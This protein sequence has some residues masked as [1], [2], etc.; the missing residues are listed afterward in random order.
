MSALIAISEVFIFISNDIS[1]WTLGAFLRYGANDALK[2][3]IPIRNATRST[4]VT[5][6]MDMLENSEKRQLLAIYEFPKTRNQS[7]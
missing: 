3:V 5:I 7:Q 1:G 6:V 4:A 2:H